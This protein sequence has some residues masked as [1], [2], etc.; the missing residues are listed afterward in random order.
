MRVAE[1]RAGVISAEAAAAVAAACDRIAVRRV[2]SS[3]WRAAPPATRPSRSCARFAARIGEPHAAFVHRGA[4]SQ[5]IVDT[6]AMLVAQR[7]AKL[8]RRR[9]PRRGG[10]VRATRRRAPGHRDGRAHAAAAGGADDVRPQGGRAGS[11]GSSRRGPGS[12]RSRRR[13]PRSSEAQPGRSPRSATAESRCCASTPRSSGCASR[14]C[15]GTRTGRRSPS[16]RAPS[17]ASRAA[18]AKIGGDIVLLAQT[19]VGEVAEREPGGSSTMPHKRNP[20]GAVLGDRLRAAQPRERRDPARERRAGARARCRCLARRVARAHRRARRDRRCGRC[21]A[22]VAHRPGGGRRTDARQHRPGDA[23][24][25]RPLRL[26]RSSG[27]R[28][29]SARPPRSSTVRWRCTGNERHRRPLRVARLGRLDLGR[30]RPAALGGRRVV[31][32]DHPGHGGRAARRGSRCRRPRRACARPR[33]RRDVLVRRSVARRSGR[34]AAGADRAGAP[35]AARAR[36]H[37]CAVRRAGAMARTRRAR[38][39]RRSRGDRRCRARTLVHAA[40]RRR[41]PVPRDAA[42]RRIRRGT[43]AAATR[44]PPGT[45]AAHSPRFAHRRS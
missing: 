41:R 15:R 2:R 42:L 17:P 16:S 45:F 7:A 44:S 31:R 10:R 9:P 28:T 1:A 13:C 18:A 34:D 29:I 20:V 8:D 24:R 11:S 12:R 23:R 14:L 37:G 6:A 38:A 21:R 35:G 39:G 3:R 19:E 40:V 30:R 22:P 26:R 5:D 4:T 43:R 36:V 33:R 32:I 27:P 25:G